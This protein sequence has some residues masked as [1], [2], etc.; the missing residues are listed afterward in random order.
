MNILGIIPARYK[1][2]RLPGKSLVDI[3]GEPMIVRVYRQAIQARGLSELI[4]ATD[5]RRIA[6]VLA[7]RG[8][9]YYMTSE[10]HLNGTSR[11]W[12]AHVLHRKACDFIINIQGDEP[13]LRP[14]QID[15]LIELL[16][17]TDGLQ[18]ATL[19]KKMTDPELYFDPN[20][21][22]VVCDAE[23][24]AMYF[25]RSAVP[26]VGADPRPRDLSP[27]PI[28]K[29][30]GLYAY[31]VEVLRELIDLPAVPLEQSERLEQLRWLF[32][33]YTIHTAETSLESVSIDTLSDL[34]WAKKQGLLKR[35]HTLKEED[36]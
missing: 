19:V 8:I 17:G 25:S 14:Q 11:C 22:K 27:Y 1:S 9:P 2:S 26:Y 15:T 21:V 7:D 33:G 18:I 35:E 13:F 36:K 24:R 16:K 6:E 4:V 29:H 32:H 28:Y 20:T 23:A 34:E 5:D 12:E 30:I 31:R 3:G 10:E